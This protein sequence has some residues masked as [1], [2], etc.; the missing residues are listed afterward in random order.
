MVGPLPTSQGYTY[1]LTCIDQ[2]TCWPEA[3]SISD[4]T[5]EGVARAFIQGW[6]ARFGVLSTV[7]T[8]CGRQFKSALWSKL[9]KLL[10][11]K[12]I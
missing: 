4:I 5:A 3:I 6:I 10:G 8:D 11:S 7:T 1:I 12:R 2:F 9:M